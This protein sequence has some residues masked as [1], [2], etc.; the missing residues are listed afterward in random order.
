MR[1][2][3]LVPLAALT[4]GLSAWAAQYEV[5]VDVN[6]EQDLAELAARGELSSGSFEI[7][8]DL[9]RDGVDLATASRDDLYSLP[10]LTYDQVDAIILY[11]EKRG[12]IADPVE[13]I[14]MEILTQKELERISAFLVVSDP[15]RLPVSGSVR[16][17]SGYANADAQAPPTVLQLRVKGPLDLSGGL[18][19]AFSRNQVFGASYDPSRDTLSAPPPGPRLELPKVWLRWKGVQHQAILGSFR[20][21]FGQRLTLDNSARYTPAGFYPDDAVIVPADLTGACKQSAGELGQACTEEEDH[22]YRSDD[23][24]WSEPFRGAAVR[25][26]DLPVGQDNRL[27]LTGFA[28][29]QSY[30]LYQYRL[31][32]QRA[33][34]DPNDD[35]NPDCAAPQ[36]F[37]RQPDP[38]SPSP[39]FAYTTL[40]NFYEELAGGGNATLKVGPRMQVGLTAYYAGLMFHQQPMRLDLQEWDRRPFG[41][42]YG[43]VG[44]D[45]AL[46]LGALNFFIEGA[47]SFDSEPG[48]GGGFA[49]VQ[50]STLS[51]K[52]Q[53]L[54]LSVRYYDGNYNNPYARAIASPDLQEGARVRN[55]AGFRVT[56]SGRP[57]PDL[58]VRTSVNG[59]ALPQ[60]AGTPGTAGTTNLYLNA[61]ADFL[62]WKEIDFGG[63]VDF[64][65][66]NLA[67][68]G[69]GDCY[70]D[71]DLIVSGEPQPCSGEY[72]RAAVRVRS[73]AFRGKLVASAQYHF[74]KLSEARY[75]DRLRDDRV[76]WAELSSRPTT[77]LQFRVRTRYR[78]EDISDNQH[79]EQSLWTF[80]EAAYL[81]PRAWRA[82]LRYDAF[83][84]LDQRASTLLRLPN[85]EHRFR[86]E[87]EAR[88]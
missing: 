67:R 75:P 18:V 2:S 74:I 52:K 33:C 60:D 23:F 21:G 68:G 12:G 32:D 8:A 27:A 43:A 49:V 6:T 62:G 28:S 58:A 46:K 87:L 63:W 77:N 24:S 11:R 70:D 16:L 72:Y 71:S 59:W 19:A 39:R 57:L 17:L 83:A 15:G 37:V 10:N 53:E 35:D 73:D 22:T 81:I 50:R 84:Y 61:R 76:V 86:L 80:V 45:G 34:S 69:A 82:S 42:P 85:P 56:Y 65:D 88:F 51:L 66:K 1:L 54:E 25:V 55:E 38:L 36:I 44:V 26:D 13:L 41:G 9:L 40:N 79:L 30:G 48:R 29:Y 3:G 20:I 64:R 4:L 7:L 5:E 78:F 31:Y 47:R 14:S